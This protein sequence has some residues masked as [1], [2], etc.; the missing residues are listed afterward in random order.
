MISVGFCPSAAE[1]AKRL[2]GGN[3]TGMQRQTV[4][5]QKSAV[6][7]PPAAPVTPAA[8]AAPAG[9]RWLGPIAGLAAGVGLGYLFSQGGFGGIASII[10][11][12]LIGLMVFGGVMLAIRFF[13]KSRVPMETAG[14][15][16]NYPMLEQESVI[17]QSR[18]TSNLQPGSNIPYDF[19]SVNFIKHAKLSFI[20][21]QKAN[22]DNDIEMIR[23]MSTDEMFAV[24]K[25]QLDLR[26]G[27]QQHTEVVTLDAELLEVVTET[28]QHVQMHV[29]S[30]RFVGMIKDDGETVAGTFEEVWNL[31]KP[32]TGSSGWTLAGIQQ[33]A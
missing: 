16:S 2:G 7:A 5:P 6:A 25:S 21:L 20:N 3:S 17:G 33:V 8:P 26:H 15:V 27:A 4:T 18:T 32:I 1:A 31:Q 12:L 22:D 23:D 24:F 30:V 14:G 9:N 10:S 11:T 13:M 19:D 28:V 29:A